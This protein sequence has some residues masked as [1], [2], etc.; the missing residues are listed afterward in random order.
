[1]KHPRRFQAATARDKTKLHVPAECHAT[2]AVVCIAALTELRRHSY[3]PSSR[4]SRPFRRTFDNS[5]SS[6]R[7]QRIHR[8]SNAIATERKKASRSHRHHHQ[9]RRKRHVWPMVVRQRKKARQSMKFENAHCLITM[10]RVQNPLA[11]FLGGGS[12]PR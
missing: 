6:I 3:Y 9:E 10:P 5:R 4:R 11:F 2:S 12:T 7:A 1:M 8:A